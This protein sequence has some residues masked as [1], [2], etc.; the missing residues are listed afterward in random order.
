MVVLGLLEVALEVT[1]GLEAQLEPEA[2][3]AVLLLESQLQ[4]E[5]EPEEHRPGLEP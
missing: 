2:D 5:L 4:E 3:L 1:L